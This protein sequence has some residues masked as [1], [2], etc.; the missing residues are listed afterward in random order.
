MKTTFE[1]VFD[2]QWAALPPALKAHYA[3]RPFSRDRVTV[4]GTLDVE[5][6]PWMRKISWLIRLTGMLTPYEGKAVP[7]T[8]HF[9]SEPD[10]NAF[11]FERIFN[12]PGREPVVFRSRMISKRA[13]R[14]TEYMKTGA[15][16]KATYYYD[17]DK[18]ILRHAGYVVRVLGIDI[19][20]P[21]EWLVGYGYA[22]EQATGEDSFK[23]HMQ[24][25]GG[26]LDKPLY[27][28]G[29]EFRVTEVLYR[30]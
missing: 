5:M 6:H 10:S 2:E 14:V 13:H 29:G 7:V 26:L 12:F 16:W 18:V 4:E 30:D 21:I 28:Y 9:H 15:G 24:M 1:A 11:V 22:Y 20:M 17:N 8:V 19:P 23:M 3:N 25:S 27:S